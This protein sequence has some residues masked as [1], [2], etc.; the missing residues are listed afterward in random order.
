MMY[1]Q[2][3]HSRASPSQRQPPLYQL[4][5]RRQHLARDALWLARD[6]GHRK[7]PRQHIRGHPCMPRKVVNQQQQREQRE[8]NN[9]HALVLH[10]PACHSV[11]LS[12]FPSVCSS[13]CLFVH[14][15]FSP[16]TYFSRLFKGASCLAWPADHHHVGA[17]VSQRRGHK[18]RAVATGDKLKPKPVL[19]LH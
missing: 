5:R 4:C 6:H 12:V 9:N 2:N 19:E 8:Q 14:L 16:P 18:G 1:N 17:T 3:R 7:P 15:L 13:V 10:L 11:F